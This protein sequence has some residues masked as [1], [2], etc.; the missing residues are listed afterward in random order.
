MKGTI[1]VTI[2]RNAISI[3]CDKR[4]AVTF[5][6]ALYLIVYIFE[7]IINVFAKFVT[8]GIFIYL[9]SSFIH[10]DTANNMCNNNNNK[11]YIMHIMLRL[12]NMYIL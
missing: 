1:G 7:F 11:S 10:L 2:S 9:L 8:F 4:D 12:V 5:V 3:K 6:S